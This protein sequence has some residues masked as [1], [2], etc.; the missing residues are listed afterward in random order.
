MGGV[1]GGLGAV[2]LLFGLGLIVRGARRKARARRM[3]ERVHSQAGVQVTST[4]PSAGT[5]VSGEP[6][7]A[8]VVNLQMPPVAEAQ[9]VYAEAVNAYPSASPAYPSTASPAGY[10][11][12]ATP[13]YGAVVASS[14]TATPMPPLS[15]ACEAF[16]RDLGVSGANMVAIVDATCEM[17]GIK[18]TAGLSLV[19]KAEKCWVMIKG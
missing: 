3:R 4:G 16:K 13:A 7:Q 5:V 2:G 18:D 14:S 19:Q 1:I 9:V 12:T 11:A 10:P 6:L 17:L 15:E 8:S